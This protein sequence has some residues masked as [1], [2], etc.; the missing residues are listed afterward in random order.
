MALTMQSP[1]CGWLSLVVALVLLPSL[2]LAADRRKLGDFN[3]D[4]E[5]VEMFAAIEKGQIEVRLIPKDSTETRVLIENKTDRPLNVKLPEAFAGVPILAQQGFGVGGIGGGGGGRRN[6]NQN[7]NQSFGGGMGGGGGG[8]FGGGGM[9][10]GFNV[11]PEKV[12]KFKVAAVC[13]EHGKGEP[14]PN[15]P[16]EIK[17]IESFSDK[18]AVAELCRMLGTGRVNQRAAQVAAWHLSNDMSFNELAAKRIKYANGSSRPYFMVQEIRAGMQIT[19]MAVQLAEKRK[20]SPG[21]T[22]TVPVNVQ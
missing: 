20:Q 16:Y 12:G 5:T 8:G 2:A 3:P 4:D 6:N 22:D 19:A 15:I 17:P 7:Q 10:R 18:P 13:L 1:R 9:G 14:R 21:Q 11:P